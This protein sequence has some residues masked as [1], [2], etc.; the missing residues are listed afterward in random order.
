MEKKINFLQI[1]ASDT[2]W[3]ASIEAYR[4]HK[5]FQEE[6]Y[7]SHI[8]CGIKDSQDM[9]C[10]Q[11]IP[12]HYGYLPN[13]L[14]GKF[15]NFLGLQSLGYPSSF[16]LRRSELI[17]DFADV[18]ILRNLHWWYFSIG[19][20]P[21]LVATKPVI[22]RLPDMWAVTG[23]CTYSYEC[24]R[25]KAS[26]GKCPHLFEYPE[27]F[28]DTT[29]FLWKRK[30]RI[31]EKL[32]GKLVFVSP[33]LWLKKIVEESWLTKGFRC[34]LIPTAVETDVFRP[35]DKGD[36]RMRFG[37]SGKEKVI[38]FS[39]FNIN[40]KRK[41]I[42]VLPHVLAR[43]VKEIKSP[44]VLMLAGKGDKINGFPQ[45]LKILNS[46]F[47]KDD[48]SLAALY[49]ASDVYLSLSTADNLPNTLVEAHSCGLPIVTLDSGG[50]KEVIE[51]GESG[52]AVND[53]ASAADAL[54][55]ILNDRV[56]QS[57][58]STNARLIAQNRFSMGRQVRSFVSL[59]ENLCRK[60]IDER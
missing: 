55:S 43:A 6:G 35:L 39:A 45:N 19:V 27:L 58:F 5:A 41:G 9:H 29:H 50:C 48:S 1:N 8:L 12:W 23:H 51:E 4:L 20:L 28:F 37:L 22:W 14:I 13:A 56:K 40:E 44:L 33:S 30:K 54:I 57:R 53:A 3:G 60:T 32:K 2:R 11:I 18:V 16:F 46:G 15:F 34:E 10:S 7:G 59:S 21:Y 52:Y 31:Y 47:L 24:Q 17:Q 49:S 36:A 38:L 42:Y 25:W 26:C